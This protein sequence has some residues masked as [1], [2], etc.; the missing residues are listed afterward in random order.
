MIYCMIE[1]N[2]V[3]K[4]LTKEREN[5]E[6]KEEAKGLTSTR[7]DRTISLIIC[8]TMLREQIIGW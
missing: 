4:D 2:L 7:F 3:W 8:P 6:G 1:G 5:G